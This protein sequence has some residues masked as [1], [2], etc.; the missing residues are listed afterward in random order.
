MSGVPN[1]NV[2]PS[3]AHSTERYR[4]LVRLTSRIDEIERR[5][6]E[7]DNTTRRHWYELAIELNLGRRKGYRPPTKR[8]YIC[9]ACGEIVML[10]IAQRTKPIPDDLDELA[11]TIT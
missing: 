7:I 9:P 2:G 1:A 3:R 5:L 6:E 11:A 4:E 8:Q 10:S